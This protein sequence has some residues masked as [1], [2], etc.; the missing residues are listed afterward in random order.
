MPFRFGIAE[1]TE[2]P[3]LILQVDLEVDGRVERGL[4]AESLAPKW[5][6]KD[7]DTSLEEDRRELL[8][9]I[10]RACELAMQVENAP[11]VFAFWRELYDEQLRVGEATGYPPLLAGLGASL[12]E[13]ALI[14]GYCR[15]TSTS[16]SRALR[17]GRLGLRLGDI[18]PELRNNE[19]VELLPE[20]PRGSIRIRHTVGLSDPLTEADVSRAGQVDDGLPRSLEACIGAY[21][22]THFKLK[23]FGDQ[24]R[25]LRATPSDRPRAGGASSIVRIHP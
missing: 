16:F 19:P 13:R 23:L 5:F 14:D 25:D 7:P 24:E 22:L 8:D 2:V 15:A 20:R 6:T 11:T 3:H 1:M 10:E 18:H 12:V 9:V 21:G 4:A 17:E